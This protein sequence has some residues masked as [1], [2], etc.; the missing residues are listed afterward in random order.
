MIP[1]LP[2]LPLA[3][4][5]WTAVLVLLIIFV[6]PVTIISLTILL[7]VRMLRGRNYK[8]MEQENAEH[9]A[10]WQEMNRA[11]NQI[12]E[13]IACLETLTFDDTHNKITSR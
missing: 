4:V 7:S 3:A 8:A 11:L 1:S 13:R 5:D 10:Q 9:T 6:L 12:E 2:F